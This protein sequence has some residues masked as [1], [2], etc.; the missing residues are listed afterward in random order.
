[1]TEAG[2]CY[3]VVTVAGATGWNIEP[4]TTASAPVFGAFGATGS[5]KVPTKVSGKGYTVV[6]NTGPEAEMMLTHEPRGLLDLPAVWALDERLEPVQRITT[7]PGLHTF[8]S[9]FLQIR[10][11]G[12]WSLEVR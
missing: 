11:S 7:S 3:V 4:M 12:P 6:R 1:V 10:T 2:H 9:G 8:P 5:G